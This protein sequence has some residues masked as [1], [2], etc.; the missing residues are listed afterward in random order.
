MFIPIPLML[1]PLVGIVGSI[2]GSAAYG[3]LL[4]MFA[5]FEAVG[6]G[7]SNPFF[8]CIYVCHPRSDDF[9]LV[10]IFCGLM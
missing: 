4:P 10:L 2:I 1:W 7:K 5:T 9:Y 8:H 6:E 3:L